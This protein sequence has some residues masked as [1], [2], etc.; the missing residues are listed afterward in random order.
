MP[1]RRGLVSM[2]FIVASKLTR[3][4]PSKSR[5]TRENWM[6]L[7]GSL[8]LVRRMAVSPRLARSLLQRVRLAVEHGV[9][10]AG[11]LLVVVPAL[12]RGPELVAADVEPAAVRREA[13]GRR[14][15]AGQLRVHPQELLAAELELD[16]APADVR[17]HLQFDQAVAEAK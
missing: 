5:T 3:V 15:L 2:F 10:R 1:Q 6:P 8:P 16:D 12:R 11:P 9:G 14:Q 13:V 4:L 17:Q 7:R